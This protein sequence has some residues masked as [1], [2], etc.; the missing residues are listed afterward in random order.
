MFTGIKRDPDEALIRRCRQGDPAAFN[1]VIERYKGIVYTLAYRMT[2]NHHDAEDVAQGVFIKVYR[3]LDT[4]QPGLA[5]RPWLM[6]IAYHT[7]IDVIRTRR[8]GMLSL[9]DPERPV[10]GDA[11]FL[12]GGAPERVRVRADQVETALNTL[13]PDYRAVLLMRARESLSYQ[14]ISEILEVP[15]SVVKIRIFRARRML[16]EALAKNCVTSRGVVP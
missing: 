12:S 9:D 11:R 14:D 7:A 10:E 15:V 5:F 1:D 4:F 3:K 2:G 16:Q 8:P 6:R 13:P